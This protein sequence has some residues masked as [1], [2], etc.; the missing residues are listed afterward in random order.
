M[1]MRFLSPEAVENG[2]RLAKNPYRPKQILELKAQ[3]ETETKIAEL[4]ASVGPTPEGL[5]HNIVSMKLQLDNLYGEWA[6][7]K[8]E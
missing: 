3:I 6:E 4:Q 5:L 2:I 8:I 1:T 7:G